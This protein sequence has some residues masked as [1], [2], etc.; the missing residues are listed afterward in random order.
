M[1]SINISLSDS[2]KTFVEEQVIKGG[3]ASI[4]EYLLDLINQDQQRQAQENIEELLIE[5]LESGD[6]IEVTDEWWEQKRIYLINKPLQ[7]Q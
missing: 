7:E 2:M 6:S 5:G 3:Y 1:I 4:S